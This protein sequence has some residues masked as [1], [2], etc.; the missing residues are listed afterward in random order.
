MTMLG[1]YTESWQMLSGAVDK[2]LTY[3]AG[4]Y[5]PISYEQMYSAVYKCVGKQWSERLYSDLMEQTRQRLSEWSAQLLQTPDFS[6]ITEFHKILLQFFHASGGIVP[7]FAYL[8]RFY[9]ESKLHTE[10]KAELGK[11]FCLEVADRHLERLVALL[12]VAQATPFSVEPGVMA[13]VARRLHQLRPAYTAARPSLFSRWV[14]GAGP[15]MREEEL[16][17]QQ[18]QEAA[19][20][21]T[22]RAAGWAQQPGA[23]KRDREEDQLISHKSSRY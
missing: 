23:A 2:M 4:V 13:E 1:E 8:N 17:E 14:A 10:L 15:A 19:L 18:K 6:F 22:L 7:I 12:E 21:L 5:E 9:I 16:A 11:S 3:P 20:Q